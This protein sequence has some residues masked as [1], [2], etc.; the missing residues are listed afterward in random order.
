MPVRGQVQVHDLLPGRWVDVARRGK[1]AEIGGVADKDVEM[2]P[3]VEEPGGPPSADPRPPSG[4]NADREDSA[5]LSVLFDLGRCQRFR[6]HS[7]QLAAGETDHYQSR[8]KR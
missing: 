5:F 6:H 7:S 2:A 4:H 3:A 1:V 8:E